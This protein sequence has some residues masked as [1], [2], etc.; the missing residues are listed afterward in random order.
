MMTGLERKS[1]GNSARSA[2]TKKKLKM[3]EKTYLP[4]P[5]DITGKSLSAL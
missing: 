1:R 4:K 3:L 2:S 5:Q